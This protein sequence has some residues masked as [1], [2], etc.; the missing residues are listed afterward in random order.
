MQA[1]L[2]CTVDYAMIYVRSAYLANQ[3]LVRLKR[4]RG[5]ERPSTNQ[6]RVPVRVYTNRHMARYAVH[7][8]RA[9]EDKHWQLCQMYSAALTLL[10]PIE[11]TVTRIE[12]VL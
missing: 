4:A 9:R 12:Q 2:L 6:R 8:S 5:R 1:S 10:T 11:N 7:V 3:K